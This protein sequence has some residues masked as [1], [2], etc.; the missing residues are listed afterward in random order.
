M[1]TH[2][3]SQR[4]HFYLGRRGHFYLGAT[5]WNCP[6]T[7]TQTQSAAGPLD[8]NCV[9]PST[10][11]N[12]SSDLN[13]DRACVGSGTNGNPES[14]RGGDDVLAGGR[15]AAGPNGIL[16]TIP[17]GDD[18]VVGVN[19]TV[20]PDGNLNTTPLVDDLVQGGVV[21]DGPNRTCETA[22]AGD[23]DTLRSVNSVQPATLTGYDDWGNL[24][25]DFANQSDF[26]P[27]VNLFQSNATGP[28][29]TFVQS[30]IIEVE[31]TSADLVITQSVR[32]EDASPMLRI[33]LQV[34]NR[35]PLGAIQP[36]VNVHLP[37][38]LRFVSCGAS[39]LGVCGGR[40]RYRT[41]AFP[42]LASNTFETAT[43]VVELTSTPA[44]DTYL[45]S[46]VEAASSD[47]RRS[48]NVARSCLL[49][50]RPVT[51]AVLL[52][53]S[54]SSGGQPLQPPGHYKSVTE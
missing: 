48:D 32:R 18:V 27:G 24:R 47:P 51:R 43:L 14:P 4:G 22:A 50:P 26:S 38:G 25:Y 44:P 7:G 20:G 49:P 10:D 41:I 3:A 53:P 37:T 23:D 42:I 5:T 34:L 15:V 33:S 1:S 12:V 35:G 29:L 36:T 40:E 54:K 6:I 9:P 28:E 2:N 30:Q 21:I 8:F 45:I 19:I 17:S 13:V 31:N 16:D 11:A 52:R 39:G 46:S